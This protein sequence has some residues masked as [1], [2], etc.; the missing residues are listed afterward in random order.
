M[1]PGTSGVINSNEFPK[2]ALGQNVIF[3]RGN[4]AAFLAV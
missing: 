3:P 2:A 4:E 1:A